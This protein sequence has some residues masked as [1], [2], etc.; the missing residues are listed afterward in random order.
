MR[1]D[2]IRNCEI[3]QADTAKFDALLWIGAVVF[4]ITLT[5]VLIGH[6]PV[7]IIDLPIQLILHLLFGTA[8]Q[9]FI[10]FGITRI[11]IVVT[12]VMG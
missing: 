9:H 12:N 7:K 4:I 6:C 2:R 3:P 11:D 5:Q 8:Q 1:C 10:G